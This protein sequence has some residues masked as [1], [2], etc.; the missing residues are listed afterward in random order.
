MKVNT[1]GFLDSETLEKVEEIASERY[2]TFDGEEIDFVS[3]LEAEDL[4][5]R[6]G[7]L[8]TD[9]RKAIEKHAVYTS[10]ILEKISFG[11]KYNRV[12]FIA[13]AHH[14]FM[15]GTGY[16]N[17]LTAEQLP[18]EV[19]IL[20]IMDIFDSLTADDRPDKKAHDKDGALRILSAMVNEGK[21]DPELVEL[22]KEFF[23]TEPILDR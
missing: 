9:E 5:V 20:T 6:K 2:V 10:K 11:D 19:R 8:T 3:E 1:A 15:N 17:G 23:E 14:E 4:R 22:A 21:L 16:P 13:G 18:I 12:R 7:T